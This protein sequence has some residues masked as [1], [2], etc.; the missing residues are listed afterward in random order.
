MNQ[1]NWNKRVINRREQVRY[2]TAAVRRSRG[3]ATVRVNYSSDSGVSHH[4]RQSLSKRLFSSLVENMKRRKEERQRMMQNN[5]LRR[6]RRE[7]E[8]KRMHDEKKTD[9]DDRLMKESRRSYEVGTG[10]LFIYLWILISV[11]AGISLK[12]LDMKM[13]IGLM[14]LLTGG[15]VLSLVDEITSLLEIKKEKR[16]GIVKK[17]YYLGFF[18]ILFVFVCCMGIML[19]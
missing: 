18:V 17:G 4:K 16:K 7:E 9:I 8:I 19:M 1:S 14:A 11:N 2:E 12:A 6:Q 5:A 3:G 13:A 10:I 15:A